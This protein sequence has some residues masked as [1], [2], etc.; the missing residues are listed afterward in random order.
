MV[1]DKLEWPTLFSHKKWKVK[2][3]NLVVGDLVMLKYPGQFKDDYTMA[4]VTEVHPVR[5]VA[6]NY[7][8]KN[9][10]ETPEVYKSKPLLSEKVAV[11]RLHKLQLVDVD[12]QQAAVQDDVVQDEVPVDDQ[13]SQGNDV[14]EVGQSE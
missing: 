10:R 14:G 7:R 5:Q 6:I 3:D 9:S 11:H 1:W 12:L 4:K 8:K 13:F 2:K